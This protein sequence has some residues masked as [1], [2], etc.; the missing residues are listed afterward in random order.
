MGLSLDAIVL[1]SFTQKVNDVDQFAERDLLRRHVPI[2]PVVLPDPV[3]HSVVNSLITVVPGVVDGVNQRRAFLGA[4]LSVDAMAL[5]TRCV[6]C[7]LA[8]ENQITQW[9]NF[10]VHMIAGVI[11][12]SAP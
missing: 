1:L 3:E 7:T 8:F 9:R 4:P 6:E 12:M 11:C 5:S 10:D 2:G